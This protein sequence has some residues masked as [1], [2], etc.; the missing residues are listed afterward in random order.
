MGLTFLSGLA[1]GVSFLSLDGFL[2]TVGK[3]SN[4]L[5]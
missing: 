3:S 4:I 2:M 5:F 1:V